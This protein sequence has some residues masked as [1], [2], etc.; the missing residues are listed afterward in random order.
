[1]TTESAPVIPGLFIAMEGADGSGK[2]SMHKYLCDK[3][4][5][6]DVP[7]VRTRELGGTPVAE[8]LRNLITGQDPVTHNEVVDKHTR[9]LMVIASRI[10]HIKHVI[11]P[12]VALG[13]LVISDRCFDSTH[14]Y[15][16]VKDN[17][18]PMLSML[19]NMSEIRAVGMRPDY[20]V[21][22]D[23]SPE[24]SMQRTAEHDSK[25]ETMNVEGGL[26]ERAKDVTTY[27]NRMAAVGTGKDRPN[28]VIW[29]NADASI[30]E[31]KA[32]LDNFA[33]TIATD[34]FNKRREAFVAARVEQPTIHL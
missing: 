1:M 2:T 24:V 5:S 32:Q 25:G 23:V 28:S 22:M 27:R 14:V 31:V 34:Y 19:E 4:E 21:F 16:G 26:E 3:L 17:L 15:Q 12:G 6:M 8:K 10:Q 20:T 29:I 30:D 18:L 11:K 33:Q 7:V 9:L 13:K